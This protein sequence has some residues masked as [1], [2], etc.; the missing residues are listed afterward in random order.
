MKI[1]IWRAFSDFQT[2]FSHVF[3]RCARLSGFIPLR[4]PAERS[5]QEVPM[6]E[7]FFLGRSTVVGIQGD[8]TELSEVRTAVLGVY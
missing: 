1:A 8:L 4:L 6:A 7:L 3:P 5:A 2:Q